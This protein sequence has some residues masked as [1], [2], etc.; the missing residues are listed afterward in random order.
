MNSA[1]SHR[2]AVGPMVIR[3]VAEATSSTSS[4]TTLLAMLNFFQFIYIVLGKGLV[5][6]WVV[7]PEA[8]HI[9]RGD[10]CQLLVLRIRAV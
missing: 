5:S 7:T 4:P 1:Q 9:I 10:A 8:L 2:L 6:A 3:Y